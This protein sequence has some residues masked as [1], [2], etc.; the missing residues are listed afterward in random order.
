M[1]GPAQLW[2]LSFEVVFWACNLTWS[3]ILTWFLKLSWVELVI[4]WFIDSLT[5]LN[6]MTGPRVN[7]VKSLDNELESDLV[8]GWYWYSLKNEIN[9]SSCDSSKLNSTMRMKASRINEVE[10]YSSI[11]I[12][13]DA[14]ILLAKRIKVWSILQVVILSSQRLSHA[15]VS[16]NSFSVKLRIAHYISYSLFGI[17]CI[18]ITV[19]ILGLIHVFSLLGNQ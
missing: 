11:I 5:W 1:E 12:D 16:L 10:V 2:L 14:I 4:D 3:L 8:Y 6:L 15:C 9:D 7:K 13:H 18:W 17:V 19:V